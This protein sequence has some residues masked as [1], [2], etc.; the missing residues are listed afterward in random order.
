MLDRSL[1]DNTDKLA[2]QAEGREPIG[3]GR[4]K[5]TKLPV[6]NTCIFA[7]FDPAD[8]VAAY[9]RRYLTEL[10]SAGF[11]IIFVSTAP[12]SRQTIEALQPVCSDVITRENQG[13]DFASWALG[14][15]KHLSRL[16]GNLLLANDSVYGPI[17][18]LTASIEDL[19]SQDA[20]FYGLVE[21][22][23][24]RPHLQS[25]FMLFR[26]HVYRSTAFQEVLHQP[27]HMMSKAEIIKWG[28]LGLTAALTQTGFRYHASYRASKAGPIGSRF[29][30]NPT[31]SFW[32]YLLVSGRVPFIKVELLRDNPAGIPGTYRWSKLVRVRAPDLEPMIASDL[33]QRKDRF[34]RVKK[35][36]RL[37]LSQAILHWFAI[38][39][40]VCTERRWTALAA[41]NGRL[42][43][44][45]LWLRRV[46]R[47]SPR[48]RHAS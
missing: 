12:L 40:H 1:Q 43:L 36:I 27:F 15:T 45:L 8:A 25:W 21:S 42:F 20:D 4:S 24:G 23:Q 48:R 34:D 17:G 44:S 30:L 19:T 2:T 5:N 6:R 47:G 14:F 26:P 37:R 31:H 11:S 32:R 33:I 29:H 3:A 7:H 46:S 16:E 18:D 10:R 13:L 35:S 41:L 22:L 9:V 39:D 28:E 38:C